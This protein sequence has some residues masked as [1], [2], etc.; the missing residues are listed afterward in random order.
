MKSILPKFRCDKVWWSLMKAWSFCSQ[1]RLGKHEGRN[2]PMVIRKQCNGQPNAAGYRCSEH[3]AYKLQRPPTR[4]AR[5]TS[6]VCRMAATGQQ[7]HCS[8]ILAR[9]SC[10]AHFSMG[11]TLMCLA[12]PMLQALHWCLCRLILRVVGHCPEAV[13]SAKERHARAGSVMQV[14]AD[15]LRQSGKGVALPRQRLTAQGFDPHS[16]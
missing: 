12:F 4:A 3:T 15:D 5:S 6:V 13:G 16:R 14:G 2:G 9:S 8:F 11:S 7:R 10:V 1:S